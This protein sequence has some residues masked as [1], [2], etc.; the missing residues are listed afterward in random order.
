MKKKEMFAVIGLGRF[1]SSVVKQLYTMNYDVLAIDSDEN[2]VQ[3]ISKYS[4][5]AV[6]CDAKNENAL[7]AAGLEGC[8]CAVV[9]IGDVTD[10]VLTTL[11]LKEMGTEKIVCKANDL[12]HKKVLEKIG[13]DMV[14][15]PEHEMGVK[16]ATRLVSSDIL[17]IMEV[18]EKFGIADVKVPSGWQGKAIR[19]LDIRN[20]Y[21]LNIIAVKTNNDKAILPDAGY[22]FCENDMI[23]VA[24]DYTDIDAVSKIK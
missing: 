6:S 23:V 3:E 16:V 2:N 8:T 1:G 20:K 24:G 11:I 21:G 12:N 19:E 14:I 15:I 22:C 10:S 5:H 4:T 7:R 13:A 18:S 17:D 9:A